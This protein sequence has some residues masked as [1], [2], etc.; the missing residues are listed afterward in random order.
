MIKNIVFDMGGVLVQFKSKDLVK[1]LP[2]SEEDKDLIVKYVFDSKYWALTDFGMPHVEAFEYM[3]KDL[4]KRLHEIA[5]DR[6]LNWYKPEFLVEG[7][8][9]LVKEI[10]DLGYNI[11]LLSNAGTN[12]ESFWS[13]MPCKQYFDG[14]L[15]SADVKLWKPRPEIY[16]KFF[17]KFNLKPEEC[18]FI[19]DLKDNVGTALLNGMDGIVFKNPKDLRVDLNKFGIKV[20]LI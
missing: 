10:K 6:A 8:T 13:K 18:L 19:D 3:K 5:L 9:E 20:K 15:I 16:Q 14:K 11:Y 1:D 4:P 7:M 12:Q 2:I 17:D